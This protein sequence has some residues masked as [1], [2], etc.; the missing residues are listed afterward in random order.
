M[1]KVIRI[2]TIKPEWTKKSMN[3]FC[4]IE[5]KDGGLSISGV[6][7]PL[8]SGNCRGSCGQIG[9]SLNAENFNGFAPGWTRAKTM[10]FLH[11]WK[12]WHLNDLKAGCEHQ[13]WLGWE[14][15]GYDKHPSEPCPICGYKFGS[16]W[17]REE[18]P[19]N[20]LD[21]LFSL[22]DTDKTPAWI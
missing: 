8:Q 6:E 18:V 5:F 12:K 20:V 11:I 7:A 13:R 15:E 14:E 9:T 2:G 19:Q 3:V 22:P 16:A 17:N 10:I 1:N 4:E 21:F